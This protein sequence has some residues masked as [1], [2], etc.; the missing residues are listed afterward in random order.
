MKVARIYLRVSPFCRLS[1]G[2]PTPTL[3]YTQL[4]GFLTSS[5]RATHLTG[6]HWRRSKVGWAEKCCPPYLA[7]LKHQAERE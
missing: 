6:C 2:T 4:L 1:V 3:W 7:V 5:Q